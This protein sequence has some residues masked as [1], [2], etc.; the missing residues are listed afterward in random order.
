MFICP[1][2]INPVKPLVPA[3]AAVH[4]P[5][6]WFTALLLFPQQSLQDFRKGWPEATDMLQKYKSLDRE[7]S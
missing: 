4:Q 7:Y 2:D 5:T 1:K 6:R 3:T